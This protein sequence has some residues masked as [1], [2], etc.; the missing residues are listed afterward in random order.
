MVGFGAWWQV[1]ISGDAYLRL[2]ASTRRLAQVE[3]LDV[4]RECVG[5]RFGYG[6]V[7]Q[8]WNI[9][10][11]RTYRV[12]GAAG[13]W[14]KRSIIYPGMTH[15]YTMEITDREII[16]TPEKH[17]FTLVWIHG[18]NE[19]PQIHLRYLLTKP[20]RDVLCIPRR[21]SVMSELCYLWR[22]P[23]RSLPG[24]RSV[25]AGST[26]SS[27]ARRASSWTSMKPSAPAKSRTATKS[28]RGDM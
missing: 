20:L 23:A 18:L 14:A 25:P 28:T 5:K 9:P 10:E 11:H 7:W 13:M 16:L 24:E 27:A 1:L 3:L 17:N 26:S 6:V 19:S 8:H 15:K 4:L 2:W 12:G 21:N 22:P